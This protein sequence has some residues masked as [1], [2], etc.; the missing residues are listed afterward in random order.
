MRNAYIIVVGKPEGKRPVVRPRRGWEGTERMDLGE[1]VCESY[2]L[3]SSG[4]E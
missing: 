4:S 2:R 3:A 1:I